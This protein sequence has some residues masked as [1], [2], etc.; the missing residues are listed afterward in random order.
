M[1]NQKVCLMEKSG[2]SNCIFSLVTCLSKRRKYLLLNNHFFP[3]IILLMPVKKINLKVTWE[4][5]K[6]YKLIKS[7]KENR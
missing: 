4:Y 3:L 1:F 2:S 7:S 5:K 6:G